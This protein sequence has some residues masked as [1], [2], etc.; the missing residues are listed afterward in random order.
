MCYKENLFDL[1]KK[2]FIGLVIGFVLSIVLCLVE[3]R[4]IL[5]EL[6]D[7]LKV[8]VFIG[9][10]IAIVLCARENRLC[11]LGDGLTNILSGIMNAFSGLMSG[12]GLGVVF[13]AAF[14]ILGLLLLVP[15]ILFMGI[16]YLLSL[17]YF[18]IMSLFEITNLLNGKE[19]L[20]EYLD[21]SVFFISIATVVYISIKIYGSMM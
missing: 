5:D 4:E 12:N 19:K 7:I 17:I 10:P 16:N 3:D 1:I 15:I 20:C 11:F 14:A 18:T 13:G 2:T 9:I 6:P 21:K 8:M